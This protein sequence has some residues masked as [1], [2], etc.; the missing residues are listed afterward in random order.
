MIDFNLFY[1]N[2]F[3]SVDELKDNIE[4]NLFISAYNTSS[5]VIEPFSKI[6]ALHKVWVIH[7]EYGFEDNELP[8]EGEIVLFD[9]KLSDSENIK[10]LFAKF[11]KEEL[12]AEGFKICI[13]ATGFMRST[14]MF[15]ILYIYKNIGVFK[16]D[17]IYSEPEYYSNKEKTVLSKKHSGKVLSVD[18]YSVVANRDQANDLLIIA[19]GFD[20]SLITAVT[21]EQIQADVVHIF[22]FPALKADMYY[23]NRIQA[24]EVFEGQGGPDAEE[25]LAPASDPFQ[26]ANVI[27]Q[28]VIDKEKASKR[29]VTNLYLAPLSTKAHTIGFAL[30]YIFNLEKRNS[31]SVIIPKSEGYSKQTGHGLASTWFF[32][33]DFSPIL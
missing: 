10:F 3:T 5:R 4:C 17:I 8:L 7:P 16:F 31:M 29:E 28:I 27:N 25:W 21:E 1:K 18:G 33:L 2:E 11:A 14:L 6:S 23:Q 32:S 22:G 9:A 13:D 15:L 26:T 12:T 20:K 19:S 30:Y 24:A